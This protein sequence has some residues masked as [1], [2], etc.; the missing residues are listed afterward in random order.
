MMQPSSR[1]SSVTA[2]HGGQLTPEWATQGGVDR[3][4]TSWGASAE[5]DYSFSDTFACSSTELWLTVRK[6]C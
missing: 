5:T 6:S 2:T 1:C 4:G 3:N